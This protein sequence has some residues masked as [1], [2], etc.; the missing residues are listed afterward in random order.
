MGE[1]G[2]GRN[3]LSRSAAFF[4]GQSGLS[5]AH[6]YFTIPEHI[7]VA[8]IRPALHLTFGTDTKLLATGEGKAVKMDLSHLGAAALHKAAQDRDQLCCNNTTMNR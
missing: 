1:P 7:G 8:L 6:D 5:V 4:D 2:L 3:R